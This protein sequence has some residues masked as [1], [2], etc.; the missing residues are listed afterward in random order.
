MTET[1]APRFV[2]VNGEWMVVISEALA[3]AIG[4]QGR[5]EVRKADGSTKVVQVAV[6][7]RKPGRALCR[8]VEAAAPVAAPARRAIAYAP[9]ARRGCG[10]P[11]CDGRRFCDTCS[12]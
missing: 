12:G 1:T 11:G 10:A 9:R 6:V 8:I 4:P 7:E 5:V 3:S 2:K